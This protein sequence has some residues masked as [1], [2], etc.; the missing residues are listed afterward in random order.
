MSIPDSPSPLSTPKT[1]ITPSIPK[2]GPPLPPPPPSAIPPP[3]PSPAIVS[4]DR[5]QLL[6]SITGFS[7]TGLK[8]AVT[9]DKSKPK[10]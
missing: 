5:S 10:L 4:P 2:G 1:P 6:S 7:K 9:N 8:K 3:P